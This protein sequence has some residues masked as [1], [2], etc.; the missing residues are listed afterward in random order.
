MRGEKEK[1]TDTQRERQRETQRETE[2]LGVETELPGPCSLAVRVLRKEPF[3]S[4]SVGK[5]RTQ[6][7]IVVLNEGLVT[8][9][10]EMGSEKTSE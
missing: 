3:L 6:I 9:K 8:E 10:S 7:F 1:E 5:T 4:V 2:R